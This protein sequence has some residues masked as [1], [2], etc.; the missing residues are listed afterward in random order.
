MAK[1]RGLPTARK[2]LALKNSVY[3]STWRGIAYMAKWPRKRG[4]DLPLITQQQNDWFRSANILTKY[5][6]AEMQVTAR[7]A[8]KGTPLYPRDVQI[9]L[10]RGTLFSL[11]MVGEGKLYSVATRNAVSQSIDVLGSQEGNMLYRSGELWLPIPAGVFGDNLVSQGPDASPVWQAGGSGG[12]G[13]W[14]EV[15]VSSVVAAGVIE[16]TGLTMTDYAQIQILLEDF[17]PVTDAVYPQLQVYLAG[18]LVTAGYDYSEQVMSGSAGLSNVSGTTVATWQIGGSQLFWGHGSA[19]GES[20]NYII[21]ITNPSTTENKKANW[22]G[23]FDMAGGQ[24]AQVTGVGRMK[25]AGA[26]TGFRVKYSSG[27]V[28]SGTLRVLAMEI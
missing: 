18:V 9:S 28:A 7:E 1:I 25:T 19:T 27:N 2:A 12:G 26:L 3:I 6:D 16:V 5:I 4:K 15:G 10:M 23:N 22:R 13:I 14:S 11:S 20:C 24:I 8:V 21:D 17:K